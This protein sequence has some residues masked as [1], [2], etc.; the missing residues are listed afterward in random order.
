MEDE[1]MIAQVHKAK[2]NAW[3]HKFIKP[4]SKL[5]QTTNEKTKQYK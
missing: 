2:M 3:L 1:R 4:L 5:N